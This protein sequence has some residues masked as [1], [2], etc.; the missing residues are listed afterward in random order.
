MHRSRPTLSVIMLITVLLGMTFAPAAPARA[1]SAHELRVIAH[2]IA[3]GPIHHGDPIALT[4]INTQIESY[5]P[6]VI[7]LSEVCTRQRD[8]FQAAHPTW[9]VHFTPMVTNQLSCAGDVGAPTVQGQLLASP[10]PI[11]DV[12]SDDLGFPDTLPQ[13]GGADRILTFRLLCGDVAIPGHAADGLRAC[14]THLRGGQ[15]AEDH[16][17]RDGQMGTM[18][19]L[20]TDRIWDQGQA[21][22]IGGDL[23][24][25]PSWYETD[26]LYNLSRTGTYTGPGDFH[27]ADQTDSAYFGSAPAGVTCA[28]AACRT[29]QRTADPSS[30]IDYAFI[31]RNVT[32]GGRVSGAPIALYG[33]DHYLYRGLFDITY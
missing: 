4:G 32:N 19:T 21:V 16:Q 5:G 33:S 7:M 13:S 14:V 29:G 15:L 8:A 17:A 11:S 2:N 18:R 1:A 22:T 10:Y 28:A 30:K 12:T 3:G 24:A 26:N 23:N 27:E 20:L 25:Y 31:S 9:S 6:D